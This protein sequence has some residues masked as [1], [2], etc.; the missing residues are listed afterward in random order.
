MERK[1]AN[2]VK[3]ILIKRLDVYE[4]ILLGIDRNRIIFDG[5]RRGAEHDEIEEMLEI[6]DSVEIVDIKCT[7]CER[8]FSK[9][10]GYLAD[11]RM[12]YSSDGKRSVNDTRIKTYIALSND[13]YSVFI[14]KIDDTKCSFTINIPKKNIKL[15]DA[16]KESNKDKKI[17][18][19]TFIK[20]AKKELSEY[21]L[22]KE[23]MNELIRFLTFKY[24]TSVSNC[25]HEESKETYYN[26]CIHGD[27]KE[28]V[29][30]IIESVAGILGIPRNK[31]VHF[32][33]EYLVNGY[34]NKRTEFDSDEM[35]ENRLIYITGCN[36]KPFIDEDSG[37]GSSRDKSVNMAK[38]YANLWKDVASFVKNYPSTTVLIGMEDIVYKNTFLT[39][40]ELSE[41]VF[42]HSIGVPEMS[43]DR[44]VNTAVKEFHDSSFELETGFEE[45]LENYIRN[46]YRKSEYTGKSYVRNVVNTIQANYFM[47]KKIGNVL[48]KKYIPDS[49]NTIRTIEDV[50]R[51][52]NN[53][54]GLEN[55]KK[56]CLKIYQ[57]QIADP[58]NAGNERHHMIFYGNPGTGKTT[59]ARLMGELFYH[60]GYLKTE[61][62]KEVSIINLKSSFK[63]NTI[64]K[65]ETEMKEALDGVLF[66][67]EA[68]G[69]ADGDEATAREAVNIIIQFMENYKDRLVVIMAGYEDKMD[70]FLKINNGLES[71]IGHKIRFEDYSID[72]LKDIFNQKCKKQ[73]YRL[74][75]SAKK[76]LEEFIAARK[77]NDNFG[78]ARDIEN[79][80]SDLKSNWATDYYEQ[81]VGAEGEKQK[82][83]KV[84]YPKHFEGLIPKKV[85]PEI[86]NMIGLKA[87]KEQLEKFENTARFKYFVKKNGEMEIPDSFNHM[88]FMGNPGTGKTTVA[89]AIC[90]D[91]YSM[92]VLKTNKL[93][94]AER[95]DLISQYVGN[96]AKDVNDIVKKAIG[97]VLFIDE[98]YSLADAGERGNEVI[99]TLITA[100]VDHRDDTIFIFAGYIDEMKRFLDINPGI[101]SRI[102]YTFVFEDYT[103]DELME[104]FDKQIGKAGF[105]VNQDALSKIRDIMDYFCELPRS[106][107][108]RFVEHV[109]SEIINKRSGRKYNK[110]NYSV[111]ELCDVPTIKELIETST[112]GLRL[113]DP[114]MITKEQLQRTAYHEIGHAIAIY[115]LAPY[116][117]IENISIKSRAFSLGRVKYKPEHRN[118]TNKELKN[119]IVI[120]L[121][122]RCAERVFFDDFDQGCSS[123]YRRAKETA[124]NM[125]K[126]YGMCDREH[127]KPKHYMAE[128]E[129]DAINIIEKYRDFIAEFA[130][131]LIAGKE[132][133]GDEFKARVKEYLEKCNEGLNEEFVS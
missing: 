100:M 80:L 56:E 132:Y 8:D 85:M 95:K 115:E 88:I 47:E 6:R 109:V 14:E 82:P 129:D 105:T 68:Y 72:E 23:D 107:N 13:I 70:E 130:E 48:L 87:V 89:K 60:S 77:V 90:Q 9:D 52:L 38:A 57:R 81:V 86:K 19:N 50:F 113:H 123:D 75:S 78:N 51:D 20:A 104:I 91:L 1:I 34:Y 55:V 42:N 43:I 92:N 18:L 64:K 124:K 46:T 54:T 26:L 37:T 31:T 41:D 111:I 118:M 66:I 69:L 112:G 36:E 4:V 94:V 93:V 58:E 120:C 99:E 45:E 106:G 12:V 110:D 21:D 79:L 27:N 121:A 116:M 16:V 3:K 131:E 15:K 126:K 22:K 10:G 33:E 98:A 11:F 59:V 61:K 67:D 117:E 71:R 127:T 133:N 76:T 96:T 44:V 49:S 40:K 119:D 73:G 97:G 32:E 103:T 29:N 101:Q 17:S 102:G 28:R 30:E 83:G 7:K 84:F 2:D 25:I 35:S 62:F 39:N 128:A 24:N 122:G 53:L 125:I 63:N 65:I 74:H 108:G 114:E 5:H